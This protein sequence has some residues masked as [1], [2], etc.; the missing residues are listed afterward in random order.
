MHR[1][2][3]WH[4]IGRA[5]QGLGFKISKS[6]HELIISLCKLYTE[7][8]KWADFN[9]HRKK[10]PQFVFKINKEQSEKP[11]HDDQLNYTSSFCCQIGQSVI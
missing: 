9:K 4:A 7:H 5:E 8:L 3:E 2:T 10:L 6:V 11:I 1:R